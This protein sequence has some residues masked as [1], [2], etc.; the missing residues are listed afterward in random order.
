VPTAAEVV[1][2]QIKQEII[3]GSLTNGSRLLPER[4]LAI[5]FGVGRSTIREAIQMLK[6]MGLV[7]VRGGAQGGAFIKN[8]N[9]SNLTKIIELMMELE[10]TCWKEVLQARRAVEPFANQLAAENRTQEDLEIIGQILLES[11]A[12]ISDE[13]KFISLNTMFHLRIAAC[14]Q[15]KILTSLCRAI[16]GLIAKNGHELMREKKIRELVYYDH[17]NIFMAIKEQDSSRAYSL[18]EEHLSH[19]E[20]AYLGKVEI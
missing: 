15:N 11:K 13:A 6:M 10:V 9:V 3:N 14:S 17:L 19:A 1:A 18:A 16:S 5:Q 7:T 2:N 4:E 12:A 8:T 20:K